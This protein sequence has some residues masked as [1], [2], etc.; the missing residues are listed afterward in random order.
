[1]FVFDVV[2]LKMC[3]MSAT[4]PELEKECVSVYCLL[5]LLTV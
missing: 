3:N 1:M 2:G 5:D 4:E